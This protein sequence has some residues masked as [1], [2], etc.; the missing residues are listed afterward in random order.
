MTLLAILVIA[1]GSVGRFTH[2]ATGLVL[3]YCCCGPHD[4]SH[5]CHC[6]DCPSAHP[7]GADDGDGADQEPAQ[8]DPRAPTLRSCLLQQVVAH[9]PPA[10]PAAPARPFQLQRWPLPSLPTQ[11]MHP[12][13]Q[14]GP[15]PD[16]LEKPPRQS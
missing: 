7:D 6:P 11:F 1:W 13:I 3:A 15:S 5:R 14:P 16:P 8:D 10:S 4:A 2:A 9:A 12:A